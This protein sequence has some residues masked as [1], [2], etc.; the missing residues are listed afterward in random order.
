M[1]TVS[2][3]MQ[4]SPDDVFDVLD[5]ACAYPRWVIGARRIRAVDPDWPEVGSRF[6]HAI[7]TAAG[8]L[9]DSS[10]IVERDRPRRFVLE[11]RFR[12]PG[13]ACVAVD[14]EPIEG[15]VVVHLGETVVGGP[16]TSVPQ[17]LLEPLITLRNAFAIRRLR[18]VVTRRAAATTGG[19]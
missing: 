17:L 3:R 11:A 8:E 13:A 5:D 7:G 9:H 1:A 2:L 18:R 14:V 6:H 19:S 12:P 16:L 15:G 4:A 10:Q